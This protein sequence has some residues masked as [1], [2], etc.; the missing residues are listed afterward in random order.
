LQFELETDG[1]PAR[2]VQGDVVVQRSGRRHLLFALPEQLQLLVENCAKW[3]MD[4]T[5]AVVKFPFVQLY[6]IH[7]EL[8]RDGK[9][10]VLPGCF[11]L[12]SGKCKA[13]YV[14][15]LDKV[16]ELVQG[17][18]PATVA[19]DFEAAMWQALHDTF[20]QSRLLGCYF[21]YSQAV[22]KKIGNLG[23][24]TLYGSNAYI[25]N[26]CQ[27]LLSLPYLPAALMEEAFTQTRL[28]A[29]TDVLRELG[30]YVD[31][32]WLSSP[33]WQLQELSVYMHSERT[34]NAVEGWHRALRRRAN[35][36]N[37]C[38]Y[39]L[40]EVLAVQATFV[41]LQVSLWRCVL[42][43]RDRDAK[44]P[45][46]LSCSSLVLHPSSPRAAD[47]SASAETKFYIGRGAS[48]KGT[49]LT[50][51]A[52]CS[53]A[54]AHTEGNCSGLNFNHFS[55]ILYFA[56]RMSFAIRIYLIHFNRFYLCS[57]KEI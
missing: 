6:S 33:V 25:R 10:K 55:A 32:T 13:D 41:S 20:P 38:L 18:T 37:L 57:R 16:R 31:A 26:V 40:L 9:R 49:K 17:V 47:P 50:W 36:V 35:G 8:V 22:V 52:F 54:I 23:L 30:G 34:N 19:I 15:V 7:A 48:L 1:L 46:N 11:I 45:L 51:V 43:V 24:R 56:I 12:M 29:D 3:Y 39:E 42:K 5:F 27:H 14:A 44:V 53:C 4:G 21:H 28:L 2:F